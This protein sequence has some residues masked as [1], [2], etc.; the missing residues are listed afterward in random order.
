M[1]ERWRHYIIEGVRAAGGPVPFALSQWAFLFP[2]FLAIRR[3]LPDGGKV[4]DVGCGAG[5]FTALLAHHGYDV[6]GIDEDPEVV[7]FAG[8]MLDFFRSSARVEQ[9]SA[10]DLRRHH[11]QF[12]LVYSFGVVEHFDP[13]VTVRLLEEQARCSPVVLVTV[14]TRF[15]C[16][17]APV[18]DERLYRRRALDRLLR[19]A[20]LRIRESFIYGDVPTAPARNLERL[21][22]AILYR[23]LKHACTYGMAICSVGERR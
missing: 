17:A 8:E 9:G 2:V 11:G 6:V 5:I 18:T 3:I 13:D 12:D 10:F 19:R 4:L 15:T 16:Y 23:R 21:L 22:P 1:T 20:G 7:A 14:P